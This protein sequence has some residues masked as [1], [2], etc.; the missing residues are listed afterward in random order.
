VAIKAIVDEAKPASTNGTL[1]F[2]QLDLNDLESVKAAAASFAKQESKLDVLWNNAGLGANRVEPGTRTAQGI[3][4][5]VGIHCVATLLFTTLLLPQ[6]RAAAAADRSTSRDGVART[7]VL[8]V[9]SGMAENNTPQYGIDW[10]DLDRSTD[11]IKNY[12]VSKAG[13]WFLGR[14]FAQRHANDGILSLPVNPG[15]LKT[16]S[17][18][19]A[20]AALM[21]VFNRVL[22]YDPIYGSYTLLYAGLSPDLRM[23]H[24][25]QHIIQWGRIHPDDE[26]SPRTDLI[27]AMKTVDEGGLGYATKLW[28]WCETKWKPYVQ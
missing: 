2:L 19:G 13:I 5:M 20:P 15:N 1:K 7:R 3:E 27:H 24:S 14:E 10:D 4:A 6:L 18:I 25:G 8:W 9:S 21:W 23:E 17:W 11:R 22:L 16:D 26:V 28:E 12:S